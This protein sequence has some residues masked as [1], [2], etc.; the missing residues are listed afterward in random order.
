MTLIFVHIMIVH[1]GFHTPKC[2]W[3]ISWK[4]AEV[5]D[6]LGVALFQESPE[7]VYYKITLLEIANEINFLDKAR[8]GTTHSSKYPLVIKRGN[9]KWTI[10][11]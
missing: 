2:G 5:D 3:L 6:D 10:C 1:E 7:N 4:I 11:R 8:I 9:G